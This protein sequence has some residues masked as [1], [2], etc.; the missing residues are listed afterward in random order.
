MWWANA[1]VVAGGMMRLGVASVCIARRNGP[2]SCSF[3]RDAIQHVVDA[4]PKRADPLVR[5]IE[6]DRGLSEVVPALSVQV[7]A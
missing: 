2:S 3:R 4:I 5:S 1:G 7:G 6:R